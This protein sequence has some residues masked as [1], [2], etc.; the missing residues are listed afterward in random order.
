MNGWIAGGAVVAL[1]SVVAV[2]S[3][4]L[5]ETSRARI[6]A[7]PPT[8]AARSIARPELPHHGPVAAPSA[9][10]GPAKVEPAFDVVR[11]EPGGAT[12]VAGHGAPK[13][14]MALLDGDRVVDSVES[15][16]EGQFVF[17]P[18][19]LSPGRH[20]LRLAPAGGA[21][22][23]SVR[24]DVPPAVAA[25]P[26]PPAASAPAVAFRSLEI[27][28][29]GAFVVTG[30]GAAGHVLRVYLNGSF[31]VAVRPRKDGSWSVRVEKGMRPGRYELRA[32]D[33]R[34]AEAKVLA[35]AGTS[36]EY[37]GR[38]TADARRTVL[39]DNPGKAA[40]PSPAPGET[41]ST[42]PGPATSPPG[43]DPDAVTA[44]TAPEVITGNVSPAPTV[45]SRTVPVASPTSRVANAKLAKPQQA[46]PGSTLPLKVAH[47][48]PAPPAVRPPLGQKPIAAVRTGYGVVPVQARAAAP[49]LGPRPYRVVIVS[50]PP[51]AY[52]RA[53]IRYSL[54]RPAA[55]SVPVRPAGRVA[56]TWQAIVPPQ[57]RPAVLRAHAVVPAI[58]T[59]V[60]QPGDSLWRISER[61]YGSGANFVRV[62]QANPAIIRN[63]QV[64]VA[65]QRLVLPS[66]L[67]GRVPAH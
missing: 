45:L 6:T 11:S 50:P 29:S 55:I 4:V 18:P 5:R 64:I 15:D 36:F 56:G 9:P 2:G 28:P 32:D 52:G 40:S 24:V 60:V 17:M 20:V 44:T 21:P 16:A 57:G 19:P 34:G 46:P 47:G 25:S 8:A 67:G 30:S 61:A 3:L 48:R 26:P 1:V 7:T 63:P 42:S 35:T 41:A 13:I 10:A 43:P 65:G 23:K 66:T 53:S 62:V 38:D 54:M 51:S 37:A 22:G 58:R 39:P 31:V 59:I 27:E 12:V 33:V 14:K 49:R